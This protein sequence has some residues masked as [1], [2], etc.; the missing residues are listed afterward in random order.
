MFSTQVH[1]T[2]AHWGRV[3]C[4]CLRERFA[5]CVAA[6]RSGRVTAGWI[7]P[8]DLRAPNGWTINA[9]IFSCRDPVTH[10]SCVA[11]VASPRPPP[12][13]INLGGF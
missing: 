9:R 8:V 3:I 5:Q 1:N 12:P 13:P 7:T 2:P 10:T 11:V 6:Q 4:G